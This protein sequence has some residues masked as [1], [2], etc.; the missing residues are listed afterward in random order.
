M[1]GRL[2]ELAAYKVESL[3]SLSFDVSLL[4]V[5]RQCFVEFEASQ[6]YTFQTKSFILLR[7]AVNVL[8]TLTDEADIVF[9]LLDELSSVFE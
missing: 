2:T 4:V 5:N 1:V 8:P 7:L 3:F 9:V 6:S